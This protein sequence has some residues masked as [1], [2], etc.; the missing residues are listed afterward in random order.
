LAELAQALY[1]P[2]ALAVGGGTARKMVDGM[3]EAIR[4]VG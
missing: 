2:A 4:Q 1:F 3:L